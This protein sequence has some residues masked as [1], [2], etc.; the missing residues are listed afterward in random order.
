[1][2]APTK[3]FL[4]KI[5]GEIYRLQMHTEG[6]KCGASEGHVYGLLN[7]LETEIDKEIGNSSLIEAHKYQAVADVLD[8]YFYDQ[9]KM[10]TFKGFYTIEGEL[11]KKGVSRPDAMVILTAM[12]ADLRYL[13]V[14]EKMKSSDSPSECRTF[15]IDE[16]N[17]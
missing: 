2:D 10:K 4:G 3:L 7:G 8:P 14:I 15:E 9:E 5:L 17:K 12:K 6:M 16:F 13:E 1:M 11:S